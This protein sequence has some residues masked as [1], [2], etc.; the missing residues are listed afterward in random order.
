MTS[1]RDRS[2]DQLTDASNHLDRVGAVAAL[3]I[4]GAVVLPLIASYKLPARVQAPD[5]CRPSI[6]PPDN[7][8]SP[9]IK[10]NRRD[11]MPRAAPPHRRC[12]LLQHSSPI[13]LS[14]HHT[15]KMTKKQYKVAIYWF[16]NSLRFHDNQPL[17]EACQE[18]HHI[19]PLYVIDPDCPLAQTAGVRAGVIR[20]NF[21][22]EAMREINS[23]LH[24]HHSQLVVLLG[25]HWEVLPK[26]V[27]LTKADALFYEREPAEPI[28]KSD[29]QT[30]EAIRKECKSTDCEIR[31][32]DT[33]T[34]HSMET[35]LAHCSNHVAPSTF[36]GFAKIFNSLKVASEVET[37][38]SVPPLPKG[39][40]EHLQSGFDYNLQVPG[41][42]QLGYTNVENQ[43]KNRAK[44]GCV[45]VGGEDAGLKILE[46]CMKKE[47][48]V[49]TFMKPDTSP[50][51]VVKPSTTAL[52]PCKL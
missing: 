36:G 50:N 1:V 12:L 27:S 49:A 14:T 5:Y 6:I 30:L 11:W 52:S 7:E 24:T 3:A 22:L 47:H 43:L 44:G 34:I 9:P 41:L 29:S 10:P 31:G 51:D 25:K 2:T 18:S 48:Y 4:V 46:D 38:S 40:L 26:V 28:R 33:H 42:E 17:L 35:Y 37:V 19:I 45:F 39:A 23:K 32:Y 8:S 20:A 13:L 15:A 21:C 16:R